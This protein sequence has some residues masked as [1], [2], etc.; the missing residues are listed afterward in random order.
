MYPHTRAR[1]A[2]IITLALAPL[3]SAC[4]GGEQT[5]A[6]NLAVT[7]TSTSSA[8]PSTPSL[9]PSEQEASR[10]SAASSSSASSSSSKASA[11]SVAA[12]RAAAASSSRASASSSQAVAASS[13]AAAASKSGAAPDAAT[14]P[15]SSAGKSHAAGSATRSNAGTSTRGGTSAAQAPANGSGRSTYKGSSAG[16]RSDTTPVVASSKRGAGAPVAVT[17]P[18]IGLSHSIQHIRPVGGT[19][20]PGAGR[21]GWMTSPNSA[22]M[23]T[24][25]GHVTYYGPDVF[26]RLH[27]MR[28]GQTVIIKYANGGT[29][30]FAVSQAYSIDK[31]ALQKDQRVW[32][33]SPA[34]PVAL[35]TCDAASRWENARHR[36]NNYVVILRAA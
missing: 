11:S 3:L 35:I 33:T 32:G 25:L 13:Q 6:P 18:S 34:G 17:I 14:T 30:T 29:R 31:D 8:A 4:G 36:T 12:S 21:I 15:T 2:A 26:Y 1:R 22:S 7:S 19:V 28:A 5:R 16:A 23:T 10:S 9:N 27:T 20:A 24:L